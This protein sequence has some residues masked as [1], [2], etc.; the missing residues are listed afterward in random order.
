MAIKIE[1]DIITIDPDC[2]ALIVDLK[3]FSMICYKNGERYYIKLIDG[4]NYYYERKCLVTSEIIDAEI[5]SIETLRN[6]GQFN[7]TVHWMARGYK[8]LPAS[9]L[10]PEI[11]R[12][13]AYG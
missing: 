6:G 8:G 1:A 11:Q 7:D 3:D 13:L 12:K 2:N 5:C 4:E 9:E 10:I